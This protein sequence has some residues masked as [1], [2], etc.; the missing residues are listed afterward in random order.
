[1]ATYLPH[2]TLMIDRSPLHLILYRIPLP[3]IIDSALCLFEGSTHFFDCIK[4]QRKNFTMKNCEEIFNGLRS[5]DESLARV[6]FKRYYEKL[7][8]KLFKTAKKILR[9]DV[10]AEDLVHDGFLK[11]WQKRKNLN[12]IKNLEDYLGAIIRNSAV[13]HFKKMASSK[14]RDQEYSSHIDVISADEAEREATLMDD[15][16]RFLMKA[17]EMLPPQQKRVILLSYFDGLSNEEIQ[18]KMQLASS[19]VGHYLTFGRKAIREYFFKMN[20]F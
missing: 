17:I 2:L 8:Y 4:K 15:K 6:A 1:M 19:T 9:A 16:K 12:D 18:V 5:E 13:T 20:G 7:Y 11:V 3:C 14:L 10:L